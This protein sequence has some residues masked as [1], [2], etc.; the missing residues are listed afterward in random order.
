MP[1]QQR[2]LFASCLT[3]LCLLLCAFFFNAPTW[4][5]IDQMIARQY[6]KVIHVGVEELHA[7]LDRGDRPLLIDARSPEEYAVSHLQGAVNLTSAEEVRAEKDRDIVVYCSVGVRSAMLAEQL[8][9]AG[10]THV[11]NLRGSLFAWANRG[12]PVWRGAAEV[13]AVHPYDRKWGRLLD[14]KLHRYHPE[15]D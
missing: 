10:F 6:P 7:A 3:P 5:E 15:A 11:R 8:R 13:R 2:L 14:E 9:A 4:K 1:R 12:Y